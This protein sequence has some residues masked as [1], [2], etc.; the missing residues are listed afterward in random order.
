MV[1]WP[2]QDA[3]AVLAAGNR[4]TIAPGIGLKVQAF[5]AEWFAKAHEYGV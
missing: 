2:G 5:L 4:E 3:V 1:G